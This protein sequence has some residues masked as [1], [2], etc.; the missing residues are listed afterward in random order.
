M[1]PSWGFDNRTLREAA[2]DKF[3]GTVDVPELLEKLSSANGTQNR[4]TGTI[5]SL[6]EIARE[7][8]GSTFHQNGGTEEGALEDSDIYDD[9]GED[10]IQKLDVVLQERVPEAITAGLSESGSKNLKDLLEKYKAVFE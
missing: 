6:T 2:F 3:G 10:P 1:L 9:Q 4:T 5:Q 8:W 7:L